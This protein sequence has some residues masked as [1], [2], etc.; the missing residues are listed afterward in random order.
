MLILLKNIWKKGA[1]ISEDTKL[2]LKKML[3]YDPK[4]RITWEELFNH[5]YFSEYIGQL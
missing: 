3:A 1:Q 5:N 2:L 4:E